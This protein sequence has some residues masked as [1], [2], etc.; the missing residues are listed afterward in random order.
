MKNILTKLINITTTTQTKNKKTSQNGTKN[1]TCKTGNGRSDSTRMGHETTPLIMPGKPGKNPTFYCGKIKGYT[2]WCKDESRAM[3]FTL[4]THAEHELKAILKYQ[5][6]KRC[7]IAM[8]ED[9]IEGPLPALLH[10]KIK[11]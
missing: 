2:Y 5:G 11:K 10:L 8:K 3:R 6:H 1:I 9:P 7:C 4:T